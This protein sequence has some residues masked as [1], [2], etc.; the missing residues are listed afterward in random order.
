MVSGQSYMVERLA[1]GAVGLGHQ[2]LVLS[3]SD[4]PRPYEESHDGLRI[5]RLPSWRN[6]FRVGQRFSAWGYSQ[7]RS[8]LRDFGADVVHLHDP[9][10]SGLAGARAAHSLGI[11][12]LLTTHALPWLI[13]A[14]LPKVGGIPALV[15]S[16]SWRYATWFIRT[17]CDMVVSPSHF[18]A[19][20][21]RTHTGAKVRVVSNGAELGRF[22]AKPLSKVEEQ[23]LRKRYGIPLRVPI[24]LH[25][26]RLDKDKN[27]PAT[28]RAAAGAM[29]KSKAHLLIVG[30]G[31]ERE[32][33]EAQCRELGIAERTHFPGYVDSQGDLPKVFRLAKVFVTASEIEVQSLVMLE[34]V[35]SGL[36]VVAVDATSIS[37][38][39]ENGK[40][41]YL[42]R[43]GDE[44]GMGVAIS[45]L[46]ANTKSRSFSRRARAI[47]EQ[48]TLERTFAGYETLYEELIRTQKRKTSR[49][50]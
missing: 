21:I 2:V 45:K 44:K 3:A 23:R 30:D 19:R 39:V 38:L 8:A 46:L 36:P 20:I 6:P 16:I 42:V 5:K 37:E 50:H 22:Q 48:H 27:V 43:S 11:P 33:L 12:V 24:I 29:K 35:A 14:Y 18:V 4:R 28:I 47:A 13:N 34:A 7:M 1:K 15:E 10:N 31:V 32:D 41:G 25:V 17:Q 26:G 9:V 49:T 40:S